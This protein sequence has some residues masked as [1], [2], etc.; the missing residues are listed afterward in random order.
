MSRDCPWWDDT[1]TWDVCIEERVQELVQL[2]SFGML[3]FRTDPGWWVDVNVPGVSESDEDCSSSTAN[4]NGY[5]SQVQN[6]WVRHNTA[7]ARG[8]CYSDSDWTSQGKGSDTWLEL[9]VLRQWWTELIWSQET[10]QDKNVKGKVLC[11]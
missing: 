10:L 1:R 5:R 2:R 4:P 7:G 6:E 8:M 11:T 3:V 9:Q